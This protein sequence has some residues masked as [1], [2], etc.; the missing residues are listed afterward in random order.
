MLGGGWKLVRRVP[1]SNAWHRANDRLGLGGSELDLYPDGDFDDDPMGE[2]E[3]SVFFD[4]SNVLDVM[5]ATG[6]GSKWMVLSWEILERIDLESESLTSSSLHISLS[7][8]SSVP[9]DVNWDP[10]YIFIRALLF[11]NFNYR[12]G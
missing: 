7:S 2:D 9:Y 10:R 5:F 1:S 11:S 4:T 8:E 3:F 6:D 12:D